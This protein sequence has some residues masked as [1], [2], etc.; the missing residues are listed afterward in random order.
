MINRS[1]IRLLAL[2]SLAATGCEP[3]YVDYTPYDPPVV[4][5]PGPPVVVVDDPGYTPVAVGDTCDGIPDAGQCDG[6]YLSF[7]HEG[8]LFT[9]YCPDYG[10]R[11]AWDTEYH[12]YECL[13]PGVGGEPVDYTPDTCGGLGTE[14]TCTGDVLSYCD[15]GTL[16][17]TDCG[18]AGDMCGYDGSAG[19]YNCL[20]PVVDPD[21]IPVD[22]EPRNPLAELR[23]EGHADKVGGSGYNLELSRRR[24]EAVRAGL[25]A[26]GI[27]GGIIRVVGFGFDR[28]TVT[29]HPAP[30]EK[31]VWQNRRAEVVW[32]TKR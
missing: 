32:F 3:Y 23:V 7:C 27:R 22:D 12:W 31:G 9:Y 17:T 1:T 21:P 16:V 13:P 5:D 18:A 29:D 6:E 14:G 24:A 8:E 30:D 11:C 26:R 10:R 25:I 28:P 4:Y 2:A 19:Y 15:A 20:A